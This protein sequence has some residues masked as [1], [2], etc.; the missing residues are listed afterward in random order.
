[1]PDG[2]AQEP[3]GWNRVVL[4]VVDLPAFIADLKKTGLHFRNDIE[5]GPGGRQVQIE[6]P[7]G[8]AIELFEPAR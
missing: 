8:N 1:M 4:K 7:D 3:G 5:E 2:Q 6:D